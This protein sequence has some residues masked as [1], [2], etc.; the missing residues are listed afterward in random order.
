MK[1]KMLFVLFAVFTFSFAFSAT[2]T[3]K[4]LFHDDFEGDKVDQ[5]PSK[6]I[7]G[8]KGSTKAK[9][10]ADPQDAKNK[11]ILTGD[12]P[13][14]QARHDVGG[15]VYVAGDENWADYIAEFDMM[16]PDDYYMGVVFRFT[17]GEAFYLS[18]RRQGGN[19][20]N[21]Y[22]RQGGTWTQVQAGSV[23]NK[24]LVWY[25]AQLTLAGDAFTFKLKERDDKTSFDKVKPATEGKDAA[26]KKG[27][28]G[29][30]GLVYLDNIFI[31]DTVADLVLAV[32]SE[33]KLSTTWSA[34]KNSH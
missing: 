34:I 23:P 32:D 12:K 10:V 31:G 9:V 24:P 11:V 21:F 3:A 4:L 20:Y 33:G 8:H 18:D 14:G 13:S 6:W 30:Y 28:F 27:K 2:S 17:G 19:A 26:F 5:E 25:R 22:R 16:F 1:F 15:S 29:H 7:L